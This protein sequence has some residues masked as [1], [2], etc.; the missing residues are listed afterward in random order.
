M[1]CCG[2]DEARRDLVRNRAGLLLWCVPAALIVIG[3]VWSDA[4][5]MLWIPSYGIM[6]IACLHNARRCGRLHCH[7]TG[8]LY[9]LGAVATALEAFAIVPIGWTWIFLSTAV[10]TAASFALERVRGTYV[11][12]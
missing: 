7:L 6:G 12:R 3:A 10:G 1:S 2:P 5:A 4:R 9:L 11:P 8:P